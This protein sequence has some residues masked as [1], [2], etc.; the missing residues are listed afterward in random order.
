[1]KHMYHI[2]VIWK[3]ILKILVYIYTNFWY[4]NAGPKAKFKEFSL[5]EINTYLIIPI[6]NSY[7]NNVIELKILLS[8]PE[9]RSGLNSEKQIFL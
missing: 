9:S 8:L 2:F 4:D 5:R 3:Y 1:M 7:I 6:P